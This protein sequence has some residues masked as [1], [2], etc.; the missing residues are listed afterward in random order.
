M[1]NNLLEKKVN[2]EEM[3]FVSM[4]CCQTGTTL[5]VPKEVYEKA[6]KKEGSVANKEFTGFYV[7]PGFCFYKSYS[8]FRMFCED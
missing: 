4:M 2:Q 1:E 8:D 3:N 5:F 7:S 6:N